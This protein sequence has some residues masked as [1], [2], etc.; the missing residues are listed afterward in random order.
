MEL[1]IIINNW[2][3]CAKVAELNKRIRVGAVSYLNTI[4][5][6]FG[7]KNSGLMNGIE[8]IEDYPASIAT[9]LLKDEIDIGL[10]PVAV[11]PELKES[12]IITDYCI[13]SEG[14]VASVAL[15][16]EVPLT[17][18]RKVLLDYQSRTSVQL[19][20]ILL[21]EYWQLEVEFEQAS[22]DYIHQ[23]K[24]STAGVII[25]D[26]ALQQRHISPYTYDLATA[27]KDH[28]GLPFVFA[29]WVA[30]KP[31]DAEFID[32]FNQAN[33]YGIMHLDKVL[34]TAYF[35]YYDLKTYYTQNIQ[36]QLTDDMRAGL[37]LF[38]EKINQ[39]NPL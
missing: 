7:I 16:S 8:L 31:I 1:I 20:R 2:F 3:L 14:D 10:I 15:F 27:W 12:H 25:G 9:R 6:I 34:A 28:T 23:I 33:K 21:K 29:A 4:P 30:N 26:R 37:A 19:V 24:G 17:E 22:L 18:V 38:L 13:G 11:I 35:E 32:A 5:F 36:Y 39:S